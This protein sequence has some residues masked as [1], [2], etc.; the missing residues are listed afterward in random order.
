M[1]DDDE[2]CSYLDTSSPDKRRSWQ[3]ERTTSTSV[4][5]VHH[6][7]DSVNISVD[8]PQHANAMEDDEELES[9]PKSWDNMIHSVRNILGIEAQE[10]QETAR[11]SFLSQSFSGLPSRKKSY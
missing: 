7:P 9:V 1:A 11:K 5:N 2:T 4:R 8:T 3:S 6:V 10:P